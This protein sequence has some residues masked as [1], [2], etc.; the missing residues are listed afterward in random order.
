M[1][2]HDATAALEVTL[3]FGCR[4]HP[5]FPLPRSHMFNWRD[6]LRMRSTQHC[7]ERSRERRREMLSCRGDQG[8]ASAVV[9]L[10]LL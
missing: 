2:P 8:I 10:K 4:N 3:H 1:M 5:R 7:E 6:A 9:R